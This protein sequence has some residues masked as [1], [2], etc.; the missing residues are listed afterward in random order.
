MRETT[1][2]G[3]GISITWRVGVN[4]STTSPGFGDSLI[5]SYA[6]TDFKI[7]KN[8]ADENQSIERYVREWTMLYTKL[9]T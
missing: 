5:L 2:L 7:Q 8:K 3:L 4:E 6:E 1:G 9:F